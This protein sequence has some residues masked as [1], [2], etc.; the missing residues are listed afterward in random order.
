[1]WEGSIWIAKG[2]IE[3]GNADQGPIRVQVMCEAIGLA[4]ITRE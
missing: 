4:G 2:D 3:A 1:M